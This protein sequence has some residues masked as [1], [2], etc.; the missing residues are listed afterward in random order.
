MSSDVQ[1]LLGLLTLLGVVGSALLAGKYAERKARIEATASP[2]ELLASRVTAA[3]Q[4][5]TTLEQER[6]RDRAYIR[7][8]VPWVNLHAQHATFSP[9]DP[10]EWLSN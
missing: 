7:A 6:D 8:I 9:P 4:R 10:P 5:I 1:V 2:Y 3:E